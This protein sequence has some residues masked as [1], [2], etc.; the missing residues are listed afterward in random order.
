MRLEEAWVPELSRRQS[1]VP[2]PGQPPAVLSSASAKVSGEWGPA[3]S[4]GRGGFNGP[5]AV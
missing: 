5:G 4:G 3:S 2:R 1:R